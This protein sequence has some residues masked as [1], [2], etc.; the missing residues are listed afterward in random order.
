MRVTIRSFT[1]ADQPAF[2]RLNLDWIE[3]HFVVEASD[4]VQLGDPQSQIIDRGGRVLMAEADGQ[5]LGTVGLVVGEAPDTVELVKMAVRR[6]ARG[7]GVGRALMDAALANARAMGAGTIWLETNTVLDRA[8]R[9][10]QQAGFE[11]IPDDACLP[12][13]Y[14]RCNCQMRMQLD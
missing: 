7:Q 14:Q 8:V 2:E 1:P 5:V 12:T 13:P 3:Q 4:R 10:Y 6:D 9:L 11:V